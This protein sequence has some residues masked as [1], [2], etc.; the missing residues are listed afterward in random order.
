VVHG[1]SPWLDSEWHG[2]RAG[3]SYAFRMPE[4]KSF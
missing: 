4:E 2:N 3:V 1:V